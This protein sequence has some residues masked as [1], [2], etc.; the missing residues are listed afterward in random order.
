MRLPRSLI[1]T[2]AGASLLVGATTIVWPNLATP[3]RRH[4]YRV[5]ADAERGYEDPAAVE[6]E[7]VGARSPGCERW[8]APSGGDASLGSRAAPWATL[9]H[10][11]E[12]VPDR[13][14]TV[15]FVS[16]IYRGG[17]EI[18]REFTARTVFRAVEPYAAVLQNDGMILDVGDAA[19]RMTFRGFRFRQTPGASGVAVYVS[20]SEG[21]NPAPHRLTFADNIFH[22]AVDED[23]LK[24]RSRARSIIVRGNV[25]YNQGSNEQHVDVNS[26]TDVVIEGN[27]FFNDFGASGRPDDGTTK[28]FIV[29]KDSNEGEDGRRGSE[30]ITIRR[31]VFLNWQGGEESFVGIGNDGKSY[32]EAKHVLIQSNLLIGNG[33]DE[34]NSPLTVFGAREVTFVNNTVVGDLPSDAFA[35]EVNIKGRNPRNRDIRFW[36]NIWSDPTGTMSQFSDGIRANTQEL[37]LSNNLYWNGEETI[38]TGDLVSPLLHDARRVVS[39][40]RLA[41]NHGSVILPVWEGSAFASG[42]TS[43]RAEFVRL[44]QAY[45]RIPAGSPAVERASRSVAPKRD[46]LGQTWVREPDLGAFE[47]RPAT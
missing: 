19:S 34:M 23:L 27:V 1:V 33:R 29:V 17:H 2:V 47:A 13:G 40:P 31:N 39:D 12:A 3:D 18:E 38:P 15:W 11:V 10:A 45:G 14:C 46:I 7:R 35:F 30:R 4:G 8:V 43:I 37:T 6:A 36:N 42:E 20:G 16:G 25:F 26:V 28:H 21:P 5:D 44:V 9:E 41:T 32:H 24:I 22:D